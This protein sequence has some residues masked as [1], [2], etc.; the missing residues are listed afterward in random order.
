MGDHRRGLGRAAEA[1]S[2]NAVALGYVTGWRF[3]R[4]LPERSALRLFTRIADSVHRRDANCQRR[5]RTRAVA[6]L[7]TPRWAVS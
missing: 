7:M 4:L 5:A 6:D 3:V 2:Q 1:A